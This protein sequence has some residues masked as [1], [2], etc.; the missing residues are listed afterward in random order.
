MSHPTVSKTSVFKVWYGIVRLVDGATGWEIHVRKTFICAVPSAN[1]SMVIFTR[2][3]QLILCKMGPCSYK[4]N[5]Q[6][7]CNTIINEWTLWHR[8]RNIFSTMTIDQFSVLLAGQWTRWRL[9]WHCR[10]ERK[11]TPWKD[12]QCEGLKTHGFSQ[13]LKVPINQ[14]GYGTDFSNKFT[15]GSQPK[16][17]HN[18]LM[19]YSK[20]AV[21][22]LLPHWRHCSL[23]L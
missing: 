1:Y 8:T 15:T 11:P 12:E 5:Y 19:A 20:V 21:F 7:G 17:G 6:T 14:N 23:A 22:P 16:T 18:I 9:C 13:N 3:H 10:S 2:P 4:E